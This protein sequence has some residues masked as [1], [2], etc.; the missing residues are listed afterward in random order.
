MRGPFVLDPQV[1]TALV[2][3]GMPAVV[4]QG[5]TALAQ[6]HDVAPVRRIGDVQ[7]QQAAKAP[8]VAALGVIPAE[9]RL[10][11]EEPFQVQDD[12]DRAAVLRAQV[13]QPIG[14]IFGPAGDAFQ[15]GDT[16]GRAAMTS[17]KTMRPEYHLPDREVIP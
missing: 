10:F 1:E 12:L 16:H 4:E 7:R 2:G 17:V 8:H 14:R 11:G 3:E 13:H 15:A 6:R 5:R 9:I